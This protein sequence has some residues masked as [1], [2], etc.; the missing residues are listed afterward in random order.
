MTRPANRELPVKI[1]DEAEKIV[2]AKGSGA[3]NLRTVARR[4]HVTATTIYHYYENKDDLLLQLK[5]RTAEKLNGRIDRIDPALSPYEALL[6]LAIEYI[7]FAEEHPHLYLL[8]IET[9]IGEGALSDS[10]RDVLYHTYFTAR[11]FLEGLPDNEGGPG[12]PRYEAMMGWVMLHGFCSLLLSGS[13]QLVE[14]VDRDTLKGLFLRFYGGE[15]GR[16]YKP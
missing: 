9:Q 3:L 7:R 12:D 6:E 15:G 5:L 10:D 14:N 2:A 1:L 8:L 11:S 13:F 4:V 16:K